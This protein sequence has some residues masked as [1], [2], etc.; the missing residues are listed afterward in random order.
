MATKN[1]SLVQLPL[2]MKVGNELGK[3]VKFINSFI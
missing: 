2:V 1:V 3:Y